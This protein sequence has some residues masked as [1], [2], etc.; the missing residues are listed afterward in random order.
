MADNIQTQE[1]VLENGTNDSL[2]KA[3]ETEPKPSEVKPS[4]QF[5]P[6]Q[7]TS[8]IQSERDKFAS[9]VERLTKAL[10]E[11][12]P[13]VNAFDLLQKDPEYR[14]AWLAEVEPDLFKNDV[15]IDE[16]VNRVLKKEFS[17]FAPVREDKDEPGTKS[18]RYYRRADKLYEQL[19]N[20][21]PAEVKSLKDVIASRK[22]EATKKSEKFLADIDRIK[23]ERNWDQRI[24]DRMTG[25][26]KDL[27]V[28]DYA[29]MFNYA[30]SRIDPTLVKGPSDLSGNRVA[31]DMSQKV[32]DLLGPRRSGPKQ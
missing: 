28:F 13:V 7:N 21:K 18:Y 2:M 26:I 4:S 24:V 5:K 10:D 15:D 20:K 22:A 19:E 1:N 16:E 9:D 30:M 11:Y 27:N 17:E 29:K 25:W 32:T 3:F 14:R 31:G 23:K 8:I 6:T 12:R